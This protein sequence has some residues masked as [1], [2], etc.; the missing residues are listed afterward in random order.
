MLFRSPENVLDVQKVEMKDDI[1]KLEI[2]KTDLGGKELPGAKLSIFTKKGE[3][4]DSW[5]SGEQPHYIEMLP[6]GEY[7]LREE[8]APEGYLVAEDVRF[9]IR[10]TAEVQKVVMK[11]E[12]KPVS[13]AET[14]RTGEEGNIWLWLVLMGAAAGGIG[15]LVARSRREDRDQ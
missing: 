3:V 11:D 10:D 13:P 14:P 2:S 5:I 15:F 1:T 6:I 8:T 12:A 9:E 7:V 4:V